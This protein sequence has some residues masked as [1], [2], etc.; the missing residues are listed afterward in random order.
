MIL[1]YTKDVTL[2]ILKDIPALAL[3]FWNTFI[4]ALPA[5]TMILAFVYLLLQIGYLAWKW[6]H[7]MNS[8]INDLPD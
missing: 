1:N 4:A 5:L 2:F 8:D 3:I 6:H 7:E